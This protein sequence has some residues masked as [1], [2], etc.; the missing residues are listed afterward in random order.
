[1]QFSILSHESAA[2]CAARSDP[3]QQAAYWGGT[4][5]Y[6]QYLQYLQHLQALKDAGVFVGGAGLQPPHTATIV[7]HGADGA[8]VVQDGLVA[9]TKEA[10][11]GYFIVE[12]PDLDRVLHWT[13]RFPKRHGTAVEVRPNLPND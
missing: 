2:S 9:D 11:G 13:A 5:Q 7:R 1:M 12:L 6:L 4:M 3:Q 8:P 10:L